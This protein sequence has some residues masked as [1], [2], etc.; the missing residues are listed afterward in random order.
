LAADVGLEL[1]LLADDLDQLG[2]LSQVGVAHLR[3]E[4]GV[5][6]EDPVDQP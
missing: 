6:V 1:D 2:A 5:G 4:A 3:R